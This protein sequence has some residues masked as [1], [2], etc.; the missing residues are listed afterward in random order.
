M[1]SK[2]SAA[3]Q[4]TVRRLRAGFGNLPVPPEEVR[5]L[6]A[7]ARSESEKQTSMSDES[8]A[9]WVLLMMES[10]EWHEHVE[11]ELTAID[12]KRRSDILYTSR[13]LESV[14]L[15]GAF[16]QAL[17]IRDARQALAGDRKEARELLGFDKA[18]NPKWRAARMDRLDG[19]PSEA[20]LS[21]HL[22]RFDEARRL[23]AYRAAGLG[24]RDRHL[25]YAEFIDELLLLFADGTKI[26]TKHVAPIVDRKTGEIVNEKRVTAWDAGY[27]PKSGAPEDHAGA[28]WNK[29]AI[30]TITRLPVVMPQVVKLQRGETTTLKEMIDDQLAKE[31]APLI[32][33]RIGVLTTD[34]GFHSPLVS[35][36]CQQAGYLINNH[37]SSHN[38]HNKRTTD[39]VEKKNNTKYAIQKYPN[40][41]ANGHR[42]VFCKCGRRAT[43]K[44]KKQ[45]GVLSVRVEGACP[46]CGTISIKAGDRYFSKMFRSVESTKT[47]AIGRRDY[48]LGNGLTYN[49]PLSEVYGKL[50]RGHGEGYN[51]MIAATFGYNRREKMP[52]RRKIQ[53]E[54]AVAI[55][56]FAIHIKA[57]DQRDRDAAAAT[58]AAPPLAA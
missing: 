8:A 4:Q 51:S 56:F 27:V 25:E 3:A 17:T 31:I 15:F 55:S 1:A 5:S 36:A 26:E 49:D 9:L 12:S 32:G 41:R 33:D 11:P 13:E 29:V 45:N 22:A 18:R 54:I 23:A 7:K 50:R 14:F 47:M 53:A 34:G 58:G 35:H 52:Y 28:G 39:S 38:K 24:A 43:K 21:R 57:M 2:S 19:V 16:R 6:W 40:W 44:N 48:D 30:T 37:A 42:E 20:S 46:K 10:P